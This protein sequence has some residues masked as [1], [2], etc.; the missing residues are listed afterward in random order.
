LIP[1]FAKGVPTKYSTINARI[2]TV[3]TKFV[4]RY[5]GAISVGRQ[6]L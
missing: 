5:P 4:G 2:E 6:K 1:F 3:Q